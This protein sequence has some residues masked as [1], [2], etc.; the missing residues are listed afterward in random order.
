MRYVAAI[1]LGLLCASAMGQETQSSESSRDATS[2][3]LQKRILEGLLKGQPDPEARDAWREIDLARRPERPRSREAAELRVAIETFLR[4]SA[5]FLEAGSGTM[6][7]ASVDAEGFL[8]AYDA[9]R[10][11]DLLFSERFRT[12]GQKLAQ[13]SVQA[14]VRD[15]ARQAQ[16]AYEGKRE[17]FIGSL[18][19]S[20]GALRQAQLEEEAPSKEIL[21][22]L[23]THLSDAHDWLRSQLGEKRHPILRAGLLPYRPAALTAEAPHRRAPRR[24]HL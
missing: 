23:R 2:Q 13:A 6:Q 20:V 15:R 12:V 14:D 16:Q 8:A 21:E 1:G 5:S 3:E 22:S 19:E 24:S 7:E 9:L 4:T 17:R 10:A 11:A 18:E